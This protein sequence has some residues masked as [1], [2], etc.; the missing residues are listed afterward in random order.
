MKNKSHII[1][2]A[3]DEKSFDDYHIPNS[4]NLFHG[5]MEKMNKS[6]RNNDK[7]FIKNILKHYPDL[8]KTS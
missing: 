1:L 6:K 7:K 2:N 8:R 4:F 3:L 5:S